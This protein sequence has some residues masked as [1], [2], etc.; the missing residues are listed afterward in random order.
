MDHADFLKHAD[1]TAEDLPSIPAAKNVLRLLNCDPKVCEEHRDSA[2]RFKKCVAKL[3]NS[4]ECR[5]PN[6][7]NWVALEQVAMLDA[8]KHAKEIFDNRQT[9]VER[10]ERER[11]AAIEKEKAQQASAAYRVGDRVKLTGLTNKPDLNGRHGIVIGLDSTHAYVITMPN[12]GTPSR[13]PVRGAK[14]FPLNLFNSHQPTI[15]AYPLGHAAPPGLSVTMSLDIE[16]QPYH[17]YKLD[18]NA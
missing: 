16:K 6:Q 2:D 14:K 12:N 1:Y 5:R 11:Q 8:L 3:L 7:M 15:S 18:P 13:V 4:E 10:V 9:R 17:L